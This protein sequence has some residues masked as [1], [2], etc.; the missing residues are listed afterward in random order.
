MESDLDGSNIMCKGIIQ[1]II[2]S[3]GAP[4]GG[5]HAF[6]VIV[7]ALNEDGKQNHHPPVI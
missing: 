6:H 3:R 7:G 2:M 5:T 4:G 1:P